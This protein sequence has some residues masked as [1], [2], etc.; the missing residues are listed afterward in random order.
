MA[1]SEDFYSEAKQAAKD[2]WNAAHTLKNLQ[3]EWNALDYGNTL[4]P[5][6]ANGS[7]A[8]LTGAEIGAVVFASGEA[9]AAV[10]LGS[11][12]STNFAKVL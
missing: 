11:G 7:N 4:P 3:D 2:L 9:V 8:G 10:V 1:R 12:H 6:D 5:G